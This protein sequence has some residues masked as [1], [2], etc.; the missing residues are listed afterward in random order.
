MGNAFGFKQPPMT[1]VYLFAT[2]ISL[3]TLNRTIIT[4]DFCS[5]DNILILKITGFF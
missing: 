2:F 5:M 3:P 4:K 1:T